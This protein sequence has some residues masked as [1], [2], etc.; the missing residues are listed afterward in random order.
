MNRKKAYFNG[1]A[2]TWEEKNIPLET[3]SRFS[4]L[5]N[6]FRI[7][8]GDCVLD[9]GT[10]VGVLHPYLLARVGETGL[11]L[12]LDLSFNMIRAAQKKSLGRN[13]LCFQASAIH[14]PLPDRVCD[15]VICFA[16]FP[17]FADKSR[18]LREMARVARK[19]ATLTIAHLMSSAELIVH[20]GSQGPVAGD[21]L[22]E[23]TV[24]RKMFVDSGLTALEIRDE[25]G[26]YLARALIE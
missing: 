6:H 13:R 19:G 9:V 25:P 14:I 3:R 7:G 8:H 17:H 24:M 21:R 12:A 15:T 22:P 20:H 1:L 18:A 4:G 23:E 5:V 2:S 26:V 16:A 10:G 11:L